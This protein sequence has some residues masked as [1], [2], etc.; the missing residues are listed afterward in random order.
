MT[1]LATVI[2]R[3]AT[4]AQPDA[5]TVGAGALFYDTTLAKW[6][7]STGV[8]W[9][10]C[11]PIHDSDDVT[12]TPTTATDW[13]GDADPGSAMDA[14][15]QLAERVDDLEAAPAA[16]VHDAADVTYTPT[17]AT[18]WD[19]DADPGD[20]DNA[21]DQLAERVD[22]MENTALADHDHTGDAG[23]GG[24]IDLTLTVVLGS[25]HAGSGIKGPFTAHE[26]LTFGQV[27][28]LNA[29][30]EM[31]LADADAAAS[32]LVVAM[33]LASIDADASGSF[34]IL[35]IARDDTWAWTPGGALY[36]DTTTAGGMTQTA[37]SGTDDVVIVLGVAT[38]ADRVL[39]RPSGVLVVHT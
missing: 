4:G 32:S 20:V 21:L 38:H 14:L 26:A 18:D 23:D 3:G 30:G 6:Q 5:A 31:A 2:S 33:A 10:D 35:G 37:P 16:H 7:R 34:L 28:Y 19:G 24:K 15:D 22:D 39:F 29:D 27:C 12:Y 1:T 8:A 25:D 17:V 36:L 9:E 11:E 13:D